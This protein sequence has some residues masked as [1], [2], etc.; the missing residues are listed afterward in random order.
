MITWKLTLA[1]MRNDRARTFSGVCG[2]A[3]AVAILAW[4]IGLATTAIHQS[5]TAVES[6]TAP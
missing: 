6:A 5:A 3:A 1:G 2:I 4:Q